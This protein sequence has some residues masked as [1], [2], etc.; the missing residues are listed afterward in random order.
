MTNG[1][2]YPLPWC[3]ESWALARPKKRCPVGAWVKVGSNSHPEHNENQPVSVCSV[4]N[5]SELNAVDQGC[6]EDLQPYPVSRSPLRKKTTSELWNF[7]V[8]VLL[9]AW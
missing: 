8:L 5:L 9:W 7:V 6:R 1:T 4:S 2:S 3:V